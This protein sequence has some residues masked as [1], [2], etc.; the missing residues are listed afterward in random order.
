[1]KLKRK[2]KYQITMTEKELKA[3]EEF[4]WYFKVE[5]ILKLQDKMVNR[6]AAY[7]KNHLNA[8]TIYDAMTNFGKVV[9]EYFIEL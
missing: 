8:H 2:S 7:A 6:D 9:D 4:F 3:L 1:M 5:D